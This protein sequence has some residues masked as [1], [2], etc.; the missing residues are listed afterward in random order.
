MRT[1]KHPRLGLGS[2]DGPEILYILFLSQMFEKPMPLHIN[3]KYGLPGWRTSTSEG[4]EMKGRGSGSGA[5]FPQVKAF[6]SVPKGKSD[7]SHE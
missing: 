3:V 4:R 2:G 6:S 7:P 5:M 1:H